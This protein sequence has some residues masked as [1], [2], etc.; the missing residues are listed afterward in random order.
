MLCM[1]SLHFSYKCALVGVCMHFEGFKR[2]TGSSL[3]VRIFN[4][5]FNVTSLLL[6]GWSTYKPILTTI[7]NFY[8][9]LCM[10]SLYVVMSLSS[11]NIN[12]YYPVPSFRWYN[13]TLGTEMTLSST[14]F[15]N[16]LSF[17]ISATQKQAVE[18]MTVFPL[19]TNY[20]FVILLCNYNL[21]YIHVI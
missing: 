6:R 8:T 11:C 2:K 12:N 10:C 19:T 5:Y 14:L 15:M 7:F 20:N 4:L 21:L 1:I 17:P 16:I 3:M 13:I 9:L 18:V